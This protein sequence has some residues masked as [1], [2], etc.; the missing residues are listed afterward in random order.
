M[1]AE[2]REDRVGGNSGEPG[3]LDE[4][5]G[6]DRRCVGGRHPGCADAVGGNTAL[7]HARSNEWI[8]SRRMIIVGD[9]AMTGV[10]SVGVAV[11]GR[12][13]R[14]VRP[15]ASECSSPSTVGGVCVE[16]R[17]TLSG[18]RRDPA[19]SSSWWAAALLVFAPVAVL[20]D[21]D[22][23]LVVLGRLIGDRG[24]GGPSGFLRVS[25]GALEGV[26]GSST[27]RW[28]W[29]PAWSVRGRRV[30][31][32]R[33][34]SSV[35][36]WSASSTSRSRAVHRCSATSMRLET[37]LERYRIRRVI[38][39]F[40][41]RREPEL[42]ELLRRSPLLD[43][44]VHVVPRFFDIGVAPAGPR[45]RRVGHPALPAPRGHDRRRPGRRSGCST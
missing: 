7:R 20:D 16:R 39:A 42:V 28:S 10:V 22:E 35:S 13:A 2:L 5:A 44:D 31:S 6:G 30:P 32:P 18:L 25:A 38:V 29:A 21:A 37:I 41:L 12:R 43:V 15:A 3:G 11:A 8:G 34:P 26:A 23:E 14:R 36:R 1:K 33:T 4:Q 45:R 17:F 24:R 27:G 19:G 40:G 9:A